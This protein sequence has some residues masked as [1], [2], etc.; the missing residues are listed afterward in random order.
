MLLFGNSHLPFSILIKNLRKALY[1]TV[2]SVKV[3]AIFVKILWSNKNIR[4]FFFL[5]YELINIAF[6]SIY[7]TPDNPCAAPFRKILF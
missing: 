6:I 7:K 5:P 3:E 1:K 4:F 2:T